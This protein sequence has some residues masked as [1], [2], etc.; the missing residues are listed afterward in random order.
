MKDSPIEGRKAR[1]AS[2]LLRRLWSRMRF[3]EI[4][5]L[6]GP[7]LMGVVFSMGSFS[8]R[9]L[10]PVLIFVSASV[11]L[12]AHI[13]WLNDWSDYRADGMTDKLRRPPLGKDIPRHVLMNLSVGSI[14]VSLGLFLLL[15]PQTMVIACMIAGLGV[16]YSFPGIRTKEKA[17]LSSLSH[18]VGGALHFL[19]GYSLFGEVLTPRA[20][21][22]SLFFSLV[23]AA[24]HAT[25]EVQDVTRDRISGVR[26]QAVCF[27]AGPVFLFACFGF[28]MAIVY[29]TTLAVAGVVPNRLAICGLL[30]PIQA[31]W[32][33]RVMRNGLTES[34]LHR[35]RI[36]YRFLF[37]LVGLNMLSML[38]WPSV[39]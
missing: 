31:L 23:F 32:S 15:S 37:A 28:G 25:Q 8:Q 12:V 11:L 21:L 30:F 19:L 20:L 34:D 18:L 22:I 24:G 14:L 9:T 26:S 6:Q 39:S 35:L 38:L 5:I 33:V 4:L 29:L 13:W 3:G 1:E 16:V 7:P 10:P 17:G 2:G 27:G 36:R